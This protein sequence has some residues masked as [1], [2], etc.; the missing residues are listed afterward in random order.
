MATGSSYRTIEFSFRIGKS[1]VGDIFREMIVLLWNTLYEQ[2]MPIPTEEI[3][4]KTAQGYYD[5]CRFPHCIGS[6]DGKHVRIRCPSH[7]VSQYFN[8]K[9]FFSIVLQAVATSNYK[10]LAIDVGGWG[11][12][13]DGGTFA[14]SDFY[15]FLTNDLLPFQKMTNFPTLTSSCRIFLLEMQLIL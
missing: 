5:T 8:Y 12:Q 9:H 3:L 13:S 2:H 15:F 1:T 14:A 4:K 10:F 7:S 6:I 11:Q